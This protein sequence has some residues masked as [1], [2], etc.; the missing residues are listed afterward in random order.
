M[1]D[2][3]RPLHTTHPLDELL[4]GLLPGDARVALLDSGS[5][6]VDSV[7]GHDKW[8]MPKEPPADPHAVMDSLGSLEHSGVQFLVIPANSFDWLSE[9]PEVSDRLRSCHRFV[10]RQE[11]L[12]EIFEL[13]PPVVEPSPTERE[14][15]NLEAQQGRGQDRPSL[16]EKLRGFFFP[17]RR[18][19]PH[20]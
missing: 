4:D 1:A 6:T 11:H 12:C 20:T 7:G 13:H 14:E 2:A 19:D 10:T 18:N 8:L 3:P 16:G 17:S 15:S 9:H 5:G